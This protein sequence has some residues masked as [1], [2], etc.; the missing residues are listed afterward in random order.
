VVVAQGDVFWADLPPPAGSGPG[1]RRPVIVVQ[2][3]SLNRSR[4]QTIVCIPLTGNLRLA[5]MPQNVLLSA[6]RTGLPSDSVANTAHVFP[7]DRFLLIERVGQLD[8]RDFER[9][10][11][12]LN[13]V[14]GR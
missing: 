13:I 5:R 4:L 7:V 10:L 12:G 3:D 6:A 8:D 11:N 14:L 2:S 9:L 1:F